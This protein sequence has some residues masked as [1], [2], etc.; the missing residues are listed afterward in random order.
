MTQPSRDTMP[1]HR[2]AHRLGHD[3]TYLGSVVA[4]VGGSVVQRVHDQIGLN[5]PYSLA[6]RDTEIRRPCH[7]VPG[8]QHC[9]ESCVESRSQGTAALVTAARHDR[10]A[11]TRTHPQPESVYTGPAAGVRLE[12]PLA[13]GHGCFS[14]FGLVSTSSVT[15][16]SWQPRTQPPLVSSSILPARHPRDSEEPLSRCRIATCGRL[17]EGTDEICLGQTW[18]RAL[19]HRPNRAPSGNKRHTRYQV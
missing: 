11:C 10:A 14:S 3:K 2:R 15:M 13:L 19:V 18:P 16:K 17:F 7:S 8:R 4:T 5:R 12:S 6:N 9:P 1:L